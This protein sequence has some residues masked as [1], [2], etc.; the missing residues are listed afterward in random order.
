MQKS[1]LAE[2]FSSFGGTWSP[3]AAG[4]VGDER[5]VTGPTRIGRS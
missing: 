4:D 1:T 3:K 5:T 2:A